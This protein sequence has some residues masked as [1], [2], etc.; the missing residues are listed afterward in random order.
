MAP[1]WVLPG[2]VASCSSRG[3]SPTEKDVLLGSPSPD[4]SSPSLS[5]EMASL[6]SRFGRGPWL[7]PS[8]SVDW[9]SDG[10]EQR[11]WRK[12]KINSDLLHG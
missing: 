12:M 2:V 10:L 5:T 11:G 4:V 7:T 1:L 6:G 3:S 9:D 8:V